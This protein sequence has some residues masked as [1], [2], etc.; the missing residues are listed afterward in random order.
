M[1]LRLFFATGGSIHDPGPVTEGL[2][3]DLGW[4]FVRGCTITVSAPNG[5]ETWS[6]GSVNQIKWSYT[7]NPGAYV[8][9][10]LLKNGILNRTISSMAATGSGSFN[11]TI[12]ST[13][14]AGT[15]YTVRVTSTTTPACTDTSNGTFTIAGPQSHGY[16]SQW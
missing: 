12:P 15:D 11:W 5:G 6:A 2:L 10:E 3:K 1:F 7:G 16:N 13:Q 9:I 14:G 4:P 8:K